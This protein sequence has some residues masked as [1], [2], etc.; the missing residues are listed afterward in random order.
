MCS[1][2]FVHRL[3]M[4]IIILLSIGFLNACSSSASQVL[5]AEPSATEDN[6]STIQSTST[7]EPTQFAEPTIQ[8]TD[9]LEPSPVPPTATATPQILPLIFSEPVVFQKNHEN[10]R[11]VVFYAFYVENPNVDFGVEA[12]KYSITLLDEDGKELKLLNDI[13]LPCLLPGQK[14]GIASSTD[15]EEGTVAKGLIRTSEE[16]KLTARSELQPLMDKPLTV[17]HVNITIPLF[18]EETVA[19]LTG[20]V[21]NP[22][23]VD[24]DVPYVYAI[25]YDGAGQIIGGGEAYVG[26]LLPNDSSPFKSQILLAGEAD[27]VETYPFT[28]NSFRDM[29]NSNTPPEGASAP[30]LVNGGYGKSIWGGTDAAILLSNPNSKHAVDEKFIMAAYG[31]DGGLLDVVWDSVTLSPNATMGFSRYMFTP[32]GSKIERVDFKILAIHYN[33]A[34]PVP[35]FPYTVHKIE[36]GGYGQ[37][38]TGEISNPTGDALTGLTVHAIAYDELG[39]IIG[40]SSVQMESLP[41][42]GKADLKFDFALASLPAKVEFYPEME[43]RP[44]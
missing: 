22:L 8:P 34:D 31:P 38:V 4:T 30:I 12:V 40:G 43:I 26:F 44:F 14:I 1:T 42:N 15:I 29:L 36:A 21:T 17:D 7:P 24:L 11:R 10:D 16:G 3:T 18:A 19:D 25:V 13:Y 27:Q 2:T 6:Q 37:V 23:D 20:I 32:S 5:V 41:A 35:E 33:E 39:Q 9:T 28:R